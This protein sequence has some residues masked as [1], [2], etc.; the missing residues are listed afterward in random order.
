[1]LELHVARRI[2]FIRLLYNRD[3]CIIFA[4]PDRLRGCVIV[5]TA[6]WLA[7][8]FDK[9]TAGRREYYRVGRCRSSAS[10]SSDFI[11]RRSRAISSAHASSAETYSVSTACLAIHA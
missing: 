6:V 10:Q 3:K 11:L 1:M 4:K 7:R 9:H 8:L 5:I 2:S